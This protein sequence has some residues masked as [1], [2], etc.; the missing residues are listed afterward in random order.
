MTEQDTQIAMSRLLDLGHQANEIDHQL[1]NRI[2]DTERAEL[3]EQRA[4]ITERVAEIRFQAR[5]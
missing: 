4:A 5:R 3:E 1:E 2:T